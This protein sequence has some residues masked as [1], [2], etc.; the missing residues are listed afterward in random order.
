MKNIQS[1][2]AWALAVVMVGCG[3]DDP[4]TS[5]VTGDTGSVESDTASSSDSSVTTE[6][7]NTSS[8]TS[9][10]PTDS[11]TPTD[12]PPPTDTG[13]APSDAVAMDT[14]ALTLACAGTGGC[15]PAT[16]VCCAK[17]TGNTCTAKGACTGGALSCTSSSQ[18]AGAS[19]VCCLQG[20][21]PTTNS[22]TC[23]ASCGGGKNQLCT[24]KAE[25]PAGQNCIALSNGIK[26]CG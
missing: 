15:D 14:A 5:T 12:S 20:L 24:T 13:V 7:T 19:Q 26:Y 3:S 8:E 4:D 23:S 18:C 22:A 17:S 9:T 25:C 6:D 11:M 2:F 1:P 10:T 16:Q 21:D